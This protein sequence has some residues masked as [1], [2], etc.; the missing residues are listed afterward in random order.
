MIIGPTAG[1]Y[2]LSDNLNN[3]TKLTSPKINV[4]GTSN[5]INKQINTILENS[6]SVYKVDIEKLK[7]LDPDFII[8]QAHCDVCAV[9]FSEVKNIV[10]KY[11]NKK[12]K[13]ISLEPNTLDDVFDDIKRV[14]KNLNVE[15]EANNNLIIA[16]FKKTAQ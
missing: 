3:I 2:C 8:T 12:T 15:N 5:E 11:F 1:G 6:L 16:Q 10:D 9:S 14:A 13:I 4:D 7:K